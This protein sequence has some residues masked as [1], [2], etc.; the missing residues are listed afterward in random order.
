MAVCLSIR[1]SELGFFSLGTEDLGSKSKG[2]AEGADFYLPFL[3][4][5]GG[6][7]LIS[8]VGLSFVLLLEG[9]RALGVHFKLLG[10]GTLKASFIGF[11]VWVKLKCFQFVLCWLMVIFWSFLL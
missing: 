10:V 5:L 9:F 6:G 4:D 1:L 7:N 8:L 2:V 3:E 11:L